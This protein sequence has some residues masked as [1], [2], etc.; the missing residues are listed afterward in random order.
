[1]GKIRKKTAS[2]FAEDPEFTISENFDFIF[3]EKYF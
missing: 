2:K 1:M 3:F